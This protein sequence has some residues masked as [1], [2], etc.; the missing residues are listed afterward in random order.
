MR[1]LGVTIG[2]T[3][4]GGKVQRFKVK[5]P[6]MVKRLSKFHVTDL[7]VEK[8]KT[9]D[10]NA[11]GELKDAFGFF[12]GGTFKDD[13]RKK[14]SLAGRSM[15]TL[16]LDTLEPFDVEMIKDV[17][18]DREYIL[19][20]T[21]SHTPEAPKIRIVFPLTRD[22]DHEEFEAVSRMMGDHFDINAVDKVSHRPAQLMYNTARCAY[23][24]H[25]VYH[26]EGSW[27]DPDAILAEYDD[28]KDFGSWPRADKEQPLR[29]P[30]ARAEDPLSKRGVV[31]AFC[32]IYRVG[33]AI[34]KFG[35][36]Y[37]ETDHD[38]RWTPD[39]S[40]GGAGAIEYDDGLFLYSHH[41]NDVASNKNLNAYDLVRLSKFGELDK[42]F[43][44][45]WAKSPSQIAMQSL[46]GKDPAVA[47]ELAEGLGLEKL[48]ADATSSEEL[49]SPITFDTLSAAINSA[50]DPEIDECKGFVW[51]IA[52]AQLDESE[53]EILL[54]MVQQIHPRVGTRPITMKT[55][56]SMYETAGKRASAKL[57]DE[58]GGIRDVERD[59]VNAVL[60][61]HYE[62]GKHLKR[63]FGSFWEYDA[64]VW[65]RVTNDEVVAG[66]LLKTMYRMRIERPKE[67]R[68]L[69]LTVGESKTSALLS[70]LWRMFCATLASRDD[71]A[72]PLGLLE[73]LK[74]P[75]FNC[76]NGE[77]WVSPDGRTQLKEHDPR[78]FFTSQIP[79]DY[80][81]QAKCREWENFC[82]MIFDD[83]GDMQRHLEEICGYALQFRRNLKT[84]IL[85]HG[86]TNAGKSTVGR[87]LTTMLGNAAAS[88]PLGHY[89]GQNAHA[90]A[91]LVGK[92]LLMDEDYAKGALLPDDFI[93]KISEEK[94]I[95]ANPKGKD[96][97]DF[98][99]R[100][101]PLIIS[102]HWPATRDTTSALRN[103]AVVVPFD[104][105][106]SEQRSDARMEKMLRSE[107]SGIL[108]RFI[109]GYRRLI[110]RGRWLHPSPC[111]Q[112]WGVWAK[113]SN[114][115][116]MFIEDCLVA[117]ADSSVKAADLF[118][119]YK[120][121][122]K[123]TNPGGHA[124]GRNSFFEAMDAVIGTRRRDR[125]DGWMWDEFRTV[126]GDGSDEFD[127]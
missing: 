120:G 83:D 48:D 58:E 78:N 19:H 27:T 66:K 53:A 29:A 74:P 126:V 88:H 31:G 57:A 85:F 14:N 59:L 55:I 56:W 69:S 65:R 72:D 107:M 124:H 119:T 67:A 49:P 76:K 5:W 1:D 50:V 41:S 24:E 36:G 61:E 3:V 11:K 115:I 116:H 118:V 64:G 101:L 84:W 103:R 51:D 46:A 7:T 32:R 13:T 60:D 52:V 17:Y 111:T 104:T 98:I 44:G 96:E 75:V 4:R 47:K 80:D 28:W 121:W 81:Q 54:K 18:K 109:D 92:L 15:I 43:E 106:P 38:G 110:E 99:C 2:Q 82:D 45:N 42:G 23:G 25:Y 20:T 63:V 8:Y 113:H 108:K 39:G 87:V 22:I 94:R 77:L 9:L 102:N 37:T 127:E 62:G 89:G 34:R 105:I 86:P 125:K 95:T 71:A 16:D 100:S 90:T 26:N 122:V 114:P 93:K 73:E 97:F 30:S 40:E 123:H 68:H 91:G 6:V 70:S 10:V 79:V 12:V 35:L 21:M 112:A 33:D 117:D